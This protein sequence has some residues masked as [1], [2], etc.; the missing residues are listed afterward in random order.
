[1]TAQE[2][3]VLE[4]YYSAGA[5]DVAESPDEITQAIGAGGRRKLWTTWFNKL[6]HAETPSAPPT[7]RCPA[8]VLVDFIFEGDG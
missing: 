8:R 1:M 2:R 3:A 5:R 7:E 6:D 4:G